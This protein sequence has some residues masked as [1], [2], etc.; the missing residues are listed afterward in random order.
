MSQYLPTGQF[1]KLP[2]NPNNYTQSASGKNSYNQQPLVKDLLQIPHDNECA[3]FTQ[4]DLEYPRNMKEKSK[5]FLHVHI[6]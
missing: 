3:F 1:E 6:K 5:I 2:F 4:F